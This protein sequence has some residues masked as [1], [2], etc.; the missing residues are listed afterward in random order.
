MTTA[1]L[2]R[3]VDLAAAERPNAL[4][5]DAARGNLRGRGASPR[6]RRARGRSP[7]ARGFDFFHERI[8]NLKPASVRLLTSPPLSSR[9]P[10]R[11]RTGETRGL[12]GGLTRGTSPSHARTLP[13]SLPQ[14]RSPRPPSLVC[15]TETTLHPARDSVCQGGMFLYRFRAPKSDSFRAFDSQTRSETKTRDE[16]STN[17]RTHARAHALTRSLLSFR[18]P[19]LLN[20]EGAPPPSGPTHP[21]EQRR[22]EPRGRR[23]RHRPQL[24]RAGRG[25]R[26]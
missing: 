24:R 12:R 17:N 2:A 9:R 23:L 8:R 16:Q 14:A 7:G 18:P 6:S 5:T 21:R 15:R 26:G 13:L 25:T 19:R 4:R 10:R 1:P 3:S 11:W 20:R 22:R